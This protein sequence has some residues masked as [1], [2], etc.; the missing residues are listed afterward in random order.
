MTFTLVH[1]SDLHLASLGGTSWRT[2]LNKRI[3]GS[4]NLLLRRAFIHRPEVV[5]VA[6]EQISQTGFDHLAVTGDLS[7][8]SLDGEFQLVRNLL[9]SFGD[10][11]RI[12]VIPGNHDVYTPSVAK[13]HRFE[14]YFSHLMASDLPLHL[15]HS[16]YPY[17]KLFGP[18]AIIGISS[19]VATPPLLATGTVSE[20]QVQAL[21][22]ILAHPEVRSRFAVVLVHHHL[23]PMNRKL[24]QPF[25]RLTNASALLE[26]LVRGRVRLVCHGHSHR[27]S[28]WRAPLPDREGEMVISDS[29]S[30]SL[31]P[32]PTHR[33][34]GTFKSYQIEGGRLT[35]I[36]TYQYRPEKELGEGVFLVADE[37]ILVS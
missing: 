30:S 21:D 32:T 18:V 10:T 3:T 29:G 34:R 22:R 8:L 36:T 23:R 33:A 12:S 4:A 5:Q 11:R 24:E 14:T 6:L 27:P 1:M 35:R 37:H 28:V 2:F 25:R 20:E 19:A 16:P 15:D 7:N 17:T 9:S 13:D 26:I 31:A